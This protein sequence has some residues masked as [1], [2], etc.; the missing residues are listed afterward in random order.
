MGVQPEV[1]GDL[2]H[3]EKTWQY[4]VSSQAGK[5]PSRSSCH[6]KWGALSL[7]RQRRLAAAKKSMPYLRSS[8][9]GCSRAISARSMPRLSTRYGENRRASALRRAH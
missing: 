4:R 8:C 1:A 6:E 2:S 5:D 3:R 7:S 9:Q